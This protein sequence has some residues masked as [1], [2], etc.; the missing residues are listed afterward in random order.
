[1]AIIAGEAFTV[2]GEVVGERALGVA[3]LAV[4]GY[5]T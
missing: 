1:M 2:Q 5:F 3:L 4:G